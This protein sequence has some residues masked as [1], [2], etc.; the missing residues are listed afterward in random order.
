MNR[1]V[2]SAMDQDLPKWAGQLKMYALKVLAYLGKDNWDLSVALCGDQTMEALNSQYRG[3]AEPTDILS[4][5][6]DEGEQFP[7][8]EG[9]GTGRSLPGDIVISLDTL[10]EN[11]R[12]F[13]VSEDEELR[14]L[15]IH[16]ILHL[17]G[18]DHEDNNFIEPMLQLQERILTSLAGEY[19]LESNS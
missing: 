4:F 11:A 1:V 8:G 17:D 12:R 7:G 10:R 2:V 15:V 13:E 14:R 16:G 19:I 6:Q 5:S 9:E 3:K 18:M